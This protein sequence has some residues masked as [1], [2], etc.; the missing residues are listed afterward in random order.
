MS[1]E[2]EQAA[3]SYTNLINASITV[4]S[5]SRGNRAALDGVATVATAIFTTPTSRDADTE[6]RIGEATLLIQA[7]VQ[8][9]ELFQG[10]GP[11]PD[12]VHFFE[13]GSDVIHLT[14]LT[15]HDD[16]RPLNYL[17]GIINA[18]ATSPVAANAGILIARPS[19]WTQTHDVENALSQV[20]FG[21]PNFWTNPLEYELVGGGDTDLPSIVYLDQ[22]AGTFHA[23][24]TNTWN[25]FG[26]EVTL[27]T[28]SKGINGTYAVMTQN[29][30]PIATASV[31]GNEILVNLSDGAPY[32]NG[33]AP[34]IDYIHQLLGQH[35]AALANTDERIATEV[36]T[37]IEERDA[38]MERFHAEQTAIT[39]AHGK[40]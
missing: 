11:E 5:S 23:D 21:D 40:A 31:D 2:I 36:R 4:T 32:I 38:Q 24:Y 8:S 13:A 7:G 35:I 3:A 28:P 18:I 17:T 39:A 1:S 12:A 33:F 26:G 30:G 34:E 20:E 14:E 29:A 16:F 22:E 9:L 19:D 25:P 10:L 6:V 15:V 27:A 37:I